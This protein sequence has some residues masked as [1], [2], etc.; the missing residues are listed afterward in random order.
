MVRNLVCVVAIAFGAAQGMY[1]Q[2]KTVWQIGEF[3]H[4]SN[5][6]RL[7]QGYDY[8]GAVSDAVFTVG[9]SD[10]AKD[11]PRFQPGPA[12]GLAGGRTHPIRIVFDLPQSPRGVYM[13]R[14]AVMYE[15]PRLSYLRLT[16]N[17]HEGDFY[18]HP[19]LDYGAGDWEGTFVPQTS[20]DE[21]EIDI[22]V[23]WLRE[24]RNEFVLTA[25]DLPAEAEQSLGDIAPGV[26]GLVY[27]A[28]ALSS[29]ENA[30]YSEGAVN[31]MAEPTIFFRQEGNNLLEMVDVFA[32]LNAGAKTEG[33]I[34]LECNGANL[35]SASLDKHQFGEYH[36]RFEVPEWRGEQSAFVLVGGTRSAVKMI[37]QKKW[38]V[39]VVPH[40][41]LDIGFT[42]AREKVAELQSQ[43]IDG[44]L[45][46]LKTHPEFHWTMDGSWIAEQFLKGRSEDAQKKFLAAVRSSQIVLPPQYA[47]QHTGVA[48]LEGLIRS[49]AWSHAL[50]AKY[51]LPIGAANI[52]DVPSY[53]WSYASVLHASGVRYLA[54]AS[55]S[56]RAPIL[57]LGRWNEKSPFYWEGPDGGRVMMWYSRAYL[58]LASMF[59]SP[60]SLNAVQ[61]ALPVFLQAYS[62][63]TYASNSVIL[64]GSQLENTPLVQQQVS[65]PNEFAKTYAWPRFEFSTFKDAMSSI[66]TDLHGTMPV[67]RGDFGPYWEDGFA[68][69]AAHTAI[70]R[71]NQSR[72]LTAEKMG[73][74]PS[75]L[76]ADLRPDESLL[77]DAWRN[78]ALFDEH[79][80]TYVGATTQPESEQ[81][82]DQLRDKEEQTTRA[83]S[84]IEKSIERSWSQV[85]SFIAP[86]TNSLAVFNSLSWTRSGSIEL[87]LPAASALRDNVSGKLA[88]MDVLREEAAEP[89]P[90]FGERLERVRFRADDVPA[91]GYKMFTIVS[92]ATALA[93][94]TAKPATV[95][96]NRFYR[97]VIDPATGGLSSVYDKDLG[98][99]LVDASSQYRFG[100]YVYTQGADDMPYNSLYRYGVAQ[101]PPVLSP[102]A[103]ANGKLLSVVN[104]SLCKIIT[105]ESSAPHTPLVLTTI[106]LVSDEKRIEFKYEIHKDAVLTKE[107]VYIA[108]PFAVNQPQF[109]YDTQNGWVNP[110]RDELVGGSRE[111]Y[112]VAHWAAVSNE[113]VAAA[114]VPEDAPLVAF[115][116]IV[117]GAWPRTFAPRSATIFSWLM[118]NYWGTNF[119]PQQGGDFTFRY[120]L[121]S[122]SKL[123]PAKLTRA[124]WDAMTPMEADLVGVTAAA[125]A[126]PATHA[127]FLNIDNENVIA[128][129]WKTAEIGDESI[130]RLE[131]IAGRPQV[132]HVSSEVFKLRSASICNALEDCD[133]EVITGPSLN[134]KMGPF[135]ILTLRLRM[136]AELK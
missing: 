86:R 106:T 119:A 99:E 23:R 57:L 97:I 63:P 74:L 95:V 110:A 50:A 108:F 62:R 46:I 121:V 14:I 104:S 71:R 19:K 47:N 78:S 41:H 84:D 133:S 129:T 12:N 102:K 93:R 120:T 81:T 20:S 45:E 60:P 76:N 122:G 124:G 127:S 48:S 51:N 53:S 31:V 87:D 55:N 90:G 7:S 3:D 36:V 35:H 82:I 11:F 10:I 27:D 113:E 132:F 92:G 75:M 58:Q 25:M 105:L 6:F 61:D 9:V 16:V 39:K 88:T 4:S 130:L 28:I 70:H 68:S 100:A 112:A 1:A 29:D 118:S 89:L 134:L 103:A 73:G 32:R 34:E 17:G 22:P 42:D 126:L 24:G 135:Q 115:G 101:H 96:E 40:E 64:F 15:T 123:D 77:Q 72:I 128:T 37:A 67:V 98:R 117:R 111:W 26:G 52:T 56:W 83:R 85:E 30:H 49:L 44:V 8:V 125:S 13:L 79:T 94:E 2:S 91:L 38:T 69:D 80:W 109:S 136:E 114:I 59:G 43:S 5:E 21:K 33:G 65:L 54:A 131:E 116:D 18:F 66:E 107:A